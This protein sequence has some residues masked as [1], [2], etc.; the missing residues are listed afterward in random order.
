[1]PARHTSFR[2]FA[3]GSKHNSKAQ[4]DEEGVGETSGQTA[5][6]YF[7]RVR[8][9]KNRSG[10]RNRF[11]RSVGSLLRNFTGQSPVESGPDVSPTPSFP[12][13]LPFRL[14]RPLGPPASIFANLVHAA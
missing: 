14:P 7:G 2:R 5:G 11:L 4:V 8:F 1:M 12:E 10:R 3:F 13:R 9:S 6:S